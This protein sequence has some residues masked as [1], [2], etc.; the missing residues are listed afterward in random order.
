MG[1]ECRRLGGEEKDIQGL[2][3]EKSEGMKLHGQPRRRWEDYN[4]V[5]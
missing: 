1:G 5:D 4:S 2:W 3:V